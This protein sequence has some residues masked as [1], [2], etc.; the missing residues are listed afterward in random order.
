[1][2]QTCL[3][4]LD[5]GMTPT[6]GREMARFTSGNRSLQSIRN[7]LRSVEIM[8]IA[9]AILIASGIS[10][11]SNW[12]ATSWL[13]ANNLSGE[14]VAQALLLM[15]FVAAIRFV[16]GIYRSS[17]VGLQRQVLFNVVNC[18]MVTLR[19]FGALGILH[20]VSATIEGFFLWQGLI[21]IAT[22]M[23]LAITTYASLPQTGKAA[24]F[25]IDELIGVSRFA[26][27][28]IAITM[29]A[30]LLTQIDKLMLSRLLSLS[31]YGYYTLAA[32]AASTLYMLISP[33]TQALYPRLCELHSRADYAAF[34]DTY[35]TGAQL[36]SVLAGSV[37]IITITYSE[38][39]LMLWT[40][41][42][43]LTKSTAPILILLAL[44][45]L[46][47]GLMWMPYQ[48]QLAHGWTSFAIK[49][50]IVAVA[51]VVPA[52]FW[53]TPRYGA[54]GAA[55][56]WV[57]LNTVYILF[58]M[59]LMYRRILTTEKWAWYVYDLLLPLGAILG[60]SLVSKNLMA[61]APSPLSDVFRLVVAM[62]MANLTGVLTA[63]RLRR[64]LF[65]LITQRWKQWKVSDVL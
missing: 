11:S 46:L 18:T 64:H 63:T 34:N 27:G 32:L 65:R 1:M 5:I 42:G 25:S 47:H 55:L 61:G 43:E 12:I 10:L 52:V 24:R 29:L 23:V 37:A 38:T 49:V 16:E 45:N 6:L 22:L 7:L 53:V 50:N 21:S 3:S 33:I 4:L 40:Q 57:S 17:I 62:A 14:V 26:G 8:A 51:L 31:D 54:E 28:M 9:I 39:I 59:Q 30:L 19:S 2:L 60:A 41:D 20:W 35:H 15:G 48:A 58:G 13:Q 56:V 36:V 44:G